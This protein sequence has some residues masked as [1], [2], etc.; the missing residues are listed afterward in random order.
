MSFLAKIELDGEELNVLD[1]SFSFSQEIDY[2]GRPCGKPQGGKIE[3]LIE[4]TDKVDHLEWML[5]PHITKNGVITFYRIDNMSAQ[6]KV[7]FTEAFCIDY[8]ECFASS[9]SHPLQIFVILSAKKLT[10]NTIAHSNNWPSC[11]I[12]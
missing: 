5:A 10:V 4:A 3:I 8:K 11:R 9:G 6:K 2:T 7:E 1:C 12:T